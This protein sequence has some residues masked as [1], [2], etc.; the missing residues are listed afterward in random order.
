MALLE[1]IF[2][3]RP[4]T[5]SRNG[6]SQWI[7][8]QSGSTETQVCLWREE[9]PLQG[10]ISLI[11][12]LLIT[13]T[14]W[15]SILQVLQTTQSMSWLRSDTTQPRDLAVRDTDPSLR[16]DIGATTHS[17]IALLRYLRSTKQKVKREMFA[18][19]DSKGIYRVEFR[20]WRCKIKIS[21]RLGSSLD[22]WTIY[23]DSLIITIWIQ[24]TSRF[25][26][27]VR[28]QLSLKRSKIY[29]L[30]QVDRQWL[31]QISKVRTWIARRT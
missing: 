20:S 23:R 24:I 18:H 19:R 7:K 8:T 5:L 11:T 13:K 15:E 22:R 28:S 6:Q 17:Q 31:F 25:T 29:Q 27:R 14:R 26:L 16:K 4:K 12:L 10:P 9:P 21:K 1:Q 2:Q 3:M 30:K